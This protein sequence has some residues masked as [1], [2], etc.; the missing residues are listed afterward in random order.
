MDV[1][2][3][4]EPIGVMMLYHVSCIRVIMYLCMCIQPSIFW[5][6]LSNCKNDTRKWSH[7]NES[8]RCWTIGKL[9]FMVSGGVRCHKGADDCFKEPKLA[10]QANVTEMVRK[11]AR[12]YP[13]WN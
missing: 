11:K 3:C 7:Q 9:R 6:D 1:I 2:F 8:T 13:P 5:G 4:I 12:R 10:Y